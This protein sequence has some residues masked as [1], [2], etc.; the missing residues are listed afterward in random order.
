MPIMPPVIVT[1][2][3]RPKRAREKKPAMPLTGVQRGGDP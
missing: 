1:H 2:F 3:Y